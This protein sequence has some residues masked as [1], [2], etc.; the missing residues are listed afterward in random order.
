MYRLSVLLLLAA[1]LPAAALAQTSSKAV[2]TTSAAGPSSPAAAGAT[3]DATVTL[4]IKSGYHINAQKPTEDYLIGTKLEAKP[5][6]GVTVTKTGYPAAKY[7]TF[8]F[9]DKPL[10]VYEGTAVIKV[11]FKADASAA[12]GATEIPCKVTFQA[13]NDQQ[14]LPPST[15]DVTI[16]VE[17]GAASS[18]TLTLTGAPPD[19]AVSV[20]GRAVGKVGASGRFE[21]KDLKPGNHKV[22]VEHD[23][24]E[25]WEQSVVLTADAPKIVP[26]VAVA[27]TT[28][29]AEPVPAPV[30]AETP[31]PAAVTPVAP[32]SVSPP[33]PES[34]SRLPVFVGSAV[35]LALAAGLGVFAMTR[36]RAR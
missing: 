26:V 11:T 19:A 16:P 24:F 34:T 27:A 22:R 31:A 10:A 14:C 2:V 23:G 32:V 28:M 3:F 4:Q 21:S 6:A 20:D 13:C 15:V 12:A 7:E 18:A 35:A 8:T 1:A 5:P 30:A 25:P 9:S 29:G 17:I 36:N 33:E